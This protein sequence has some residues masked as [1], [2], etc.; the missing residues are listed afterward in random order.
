MLASV[1]FLLLTSLWQA[2][3]AA[4]A[5]FASDASA[6]CSR[7]GID[8]GAVLRSAKTS[9]TRALRLFIWLGVNA[10]FD[11]ASAEDY[12]SDLKQLCSVVGDGRMSAILSLHGNGARKMVREYLRYEYQDSSESTAVSDK[13]LRAALPLVARVLLDQ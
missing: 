1:R 3:P 8:Y 9:D 6:V 10:G 12:G 4:E 7:I 5:P 13:N 11:A 2:V